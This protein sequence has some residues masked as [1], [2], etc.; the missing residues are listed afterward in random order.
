MKYRLKNYSKNK[1]NS[2]KS[3]GFECTTIGVGTE[4][5]SQQPGVVCVS[6]EPRLSPDFKRPPREQEDSSSKKFH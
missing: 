3:W 5:V 1:T 4:I 6:L 2:K